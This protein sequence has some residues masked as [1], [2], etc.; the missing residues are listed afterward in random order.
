MTFLGFFD[1]AQKLRVTVGKT[2]CLEAFSHVMAVKM[3][4]EGH[5]RDLVVMRHIFTLED[6]NTK[7]RF[8][9]TS[10]MIK[11]GE[12]HNSGGQSIMSQTVGFTAA[13]GCRLVLEGKVQEKGVISTTSKEVYEPILAG[14]EKKGIFM[15]EESERP[16]YVATRKAKL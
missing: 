16:G 3:A 14:L 10:T 1:D 2:T 12:S 6:P 8:K 7:E 11:A 15:V 13:M 4:H 9:H 5:D